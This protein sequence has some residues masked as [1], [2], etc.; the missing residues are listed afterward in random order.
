MRINKP[1]QLALAS[2]FTL[3]LLGCEKDNEA[4]KS[5]PMPPSNLT[6][7]VEPKKSPPMPPSNLTVTVEPSAE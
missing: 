2:I 6:I 5:P 3:S 7:T 4:P 1:T